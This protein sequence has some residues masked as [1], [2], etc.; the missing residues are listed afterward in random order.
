ME[1]TL[2]EILDLTQGTLLRGHQEMVFTGIGAL[3]EAGDESVSFLGNERY[4]ND[5][6]ESDAGLVLIA[7]GVEQKEGD[8]AL[9][10][11]ENPSFAFGE[12]VKIVKKKQRS[13]KAFI[14][15]RAFIE[16]GVEFDPEKVCIKA[17]AVIEKGCKIGDGTEIGAGAEI[18]EGVSLGED[19]LVYPNVTVREHCQIGDRVI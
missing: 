6:V 2:L 1:I 17:G 19:C 18:S 9:V 11:V 10:E 8:C 14:H 7:P 15:P 16:E 13:F 5:Y 3:D 12:I 4:F